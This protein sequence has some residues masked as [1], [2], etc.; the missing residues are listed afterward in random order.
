MDS[1][2][3]CPLRDS[4]E[5]AKTNEDTDGC[6]PES[7]SSPV[8]MPLHMFVIF[9]S[10][11]SLSGSRSLACALSLCKVTAIYAIF[12][13]HYFRDESPK[14][15]LNFKTS[16]FS[17]F[18]VVTGDSW[19]SGVSVNTCTRISTVCHLLT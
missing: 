19:A 10:A 12:G 4:R 8:D 16:M 18:Q 13:T 17:M 14:Y 15:F 5:R 6:E 9:L 1:N 2:R 11:H 3:I 7:I